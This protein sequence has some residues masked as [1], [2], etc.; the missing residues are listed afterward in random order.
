MRLYATIRSERASK[1]QGGNEYLDIDIKAGT[2]AEP[3]KLARLTVRAG[4]NDNNADRR[5]GYGLYAEDD[6][7]LYWIPKEPKGEKQKGET[8]ID[9]FIEK[10]DMPQ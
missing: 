4:E 2:A 7:C 10:V 6:E 3:R 5:E 1:G 9:R 8:A